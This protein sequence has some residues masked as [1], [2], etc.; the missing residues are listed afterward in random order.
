MV[1]LLDELSELE[2]LSLIEISPSRLGLFSRCE[3][4]Y[5]YRYVL[6]EPS[7]WSPYAA[8]GNIIHSVLENTD[9]DAP[10]NY[11]DM[12]DK[13]DEHRLTYDPDLEIPNELL[14]A[15]HNMLEEF[16]QRHRG[17]EFHIVAK[18]QSFAIVVGPA[19]IVGYIDRVDIIGD[20]LIIIDFKSGANEIPVKGIPN[21]F[22]LGIYAL[23][24]SKQYPDKE[25]SAGLYYLRSGRQKFHTYTKADLEEM[26]Q[27]LITTIDQII[28]TKD[29][30]FSDNPR[31]CYWCDFK[32]ICPVGI[33]RVK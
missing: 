8:L 31:I 3:A 20:K 25:V 32:A 23:A 16:T 14:L 18:E 10:L 17:D 11:L 28:E 13:F 21:D 1:R 24:M 15:G 26:E 9:F 29:F 2:K 6:F 22:Q 33:R 19:L 30:K 7:T 4:A 5:F 27:R 12:L